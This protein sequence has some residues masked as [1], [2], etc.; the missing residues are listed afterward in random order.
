MQSFIFSM[1]CH[2]R[3][4]FFL[5]QIEKGLQLGSNKFCIMCNHIRKLVAL[6]Y[7]KRKIVFLK[8]IRLSHLFNYILFQGVIN[9]I[10]KIQNL[11]I[12][13]FPVNSHQRITGTVLIEN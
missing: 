11:A 2:T 7:K 4:G 1:F 8:I 9:L 6:T 3:Y 13:N 10:L 5:I 12:L